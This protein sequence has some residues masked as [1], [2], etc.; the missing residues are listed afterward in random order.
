LSKQNLTTREIFKPL[1]EPKGQYFIA[2]ILFSAEP[3]GQYF[4]AIILFSA[5]QR[6]KYC[7]YIDFSMMRWS[8]ILPPQGNNSQ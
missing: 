4:I 6:E 2:I 3:K 7:Q 5:D 1:A 8:G